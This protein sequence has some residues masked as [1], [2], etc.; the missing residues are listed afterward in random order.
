MRHFAIA[1]S[2]GAR[3]LTRVGDGIEMACMGDAPADHAANQPVDVA[4]C[5]GHDALAR[6]RPVIRHLCVGLVD[7][8]AKVRLIAASTEAAP[9]ES[10]GPIHVY[11]H[12]RLVWPLRRGRFKAIVQFLSPKPPS[13]VYGMACDSYELAGALASEFDVDLALHLTAARDVDSVVSE[14]A[15]ASAHRIVA[16]DRILE[17][18]REREGA[19]DA[20]QTLVRPGVL[21]GSETTCFRTEDGIASLVCTAPLEESYGVELVIAAAQIIRDRH[22]ALCTFLLGEGRAEPAL[23]SAVRSRTLSTEVTF[24]RPVAEPIDILRGTDM[25]V[26]A[27]GEEDISARPL[28]AMANGTAV[29][30][31]DGGVADYL[32]DGETAVICKERTASA[33]ANAIE[34]LL[35]DHEYAHRL[36][37]SARDYVVLH[38]P[39]S[40]M[41]DKTMDILRGITV[42]RQ[43]FPMRR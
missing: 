30:A 15:L 8:N 21:R 18:L 28:Q 22:H 13:I 33:L 32:R 5:I 4:L 7:H 31:F 17:L 10:L 19:S 3:R 34:S 2:G 20:K 16:S 23:R 11:I 43:T 12:E 42:Q 24:A 35:L 1:A 40:G 41:A 39:M 37:K 6:L 26:L 29:I 25:L 9:L 27:P 14:V 36:V 38:H